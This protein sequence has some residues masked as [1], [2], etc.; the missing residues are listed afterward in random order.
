LRYPPIKQQKR[1]NAPVAYE[2]GKLIISMI[3]I[4]KILLARW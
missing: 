1:F 4:W 2:Q 3:F